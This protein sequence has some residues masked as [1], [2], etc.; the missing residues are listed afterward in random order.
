M[1]LSRLTAIYTEKGDGSPFDACCKR[2]GF[3]LFPAALGVGFI[4]D[5]NVAPVASGAVVGRAVDDMPL[6]AGTYDN[7]LTSINFPAS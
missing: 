7:M 5:L 1:G 3:S 4:P 6:L 2:S